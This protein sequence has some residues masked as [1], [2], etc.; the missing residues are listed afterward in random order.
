[1]SYDLGQTFFLDKQALQN[2]DVGFVTSVSLYFNTKPTEDKTVTGIGAPG[3]TVAICNTKEDGTPDLTTAT[4]Y[5]HM[6]R[7]EYANINAT[8]QGTTPT[9]FTFRQP[10]PLTTNRKYAFLIKF[11]GGDTGFSVFANK[12]GKTAVSST[13][14]TQVS[15]GV[16]DGNA[17]KITNG[18]TLTPMV[19]TDFTFAL[20]VA[21]FSSTASTYL[22]RNR[23][24]EVLKT[25]SLS[26]SFI[27]GEEVFQQRTALTGTVSVNNTSQTV[28]GTG[29][30][31]TSAIVV[32]DKIVLNGGS[33]SN[34]NL[35][36]VNS[37]TNAT[38]LVLTEAPSFTNS[39]ATYYK[40]VTGKIHT[41]DDLADILVIQDSTSNSTV[42]LTTST[43]LQ[44]LDSGAT[45]SIDAIRDYTVNA[46]VPNYNV[47]APAGTKAALTVNF[48]NTAGSVSSTR[49][50]DAVLGSRVLLNKAD[51]V[52]ASRTTEVTSGVPFTSFGGELV[53]TSSNPYASPYVRRDELDLFCEQYSINNSTTNEHTGQGTAKSKYIS[54]TITLTQNQ[55][56]EDL[57]VYLSAFKP[58]NTDIAVYG[59]FL[60]PEDNESF[61]I[62]DWTELQLQ[63]ST[64][65]SSNPANINDLKELTYKIPSF[66]SGTR[67][68]GLF[69]TSTSSAV[70][71]GTS[72]SVSTDISVGD[73]VRVYSPVNSNT[74]FI[75]SVT[76]ANTT[77]FTVS[78]AV[79]N[80]SVVG[81]GFYVDVIDRPNSGFLDVQNLN[82]LTYYNKSL[83]KMVTYKTFAIKIVLL[84][85]DGVNVPY[86]ND[87]RALAVSA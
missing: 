1:M 74:H 23:P 86:V 32:G 78:K 46:A 29:T 72:G 80:S 4:N 68:S 13:Q 17:Y 19:D 6:A 44:G 30:N 63:E 81:T 62:K 33:A 54:A 41:Y 18:F 84:S 47:V 7:V 69:T 38:H 27:G 3:V 15:S 48:A 36:V 37:V 16:V 10:V 51:A 22:L 85:A 60:N 21:K 50:Q 73:I 79:S 52:I 76:A 39:S 56:A 20:K 59:K 28:I 58:A 53:F 43:T 12:A 82:I 2:S 75:E 61:D 45:V 9:V 66:Q 25:S 87:V 11:D 31:F 14:T 71:T 8:T 26:G 70:V 65:I 83:G 42:Y 67:A 24:L 57:I 64:N 5:N 40:T 49:K 55:Q 35:R 34:T 77:T